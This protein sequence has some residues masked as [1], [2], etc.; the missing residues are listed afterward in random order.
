MRVIFTLRNSEHKPRSTRPDGTTRDVAFGVFEAMW[1]DRKR[2]A[3]THGAIVVRR[4]IFAPAR[5]R[6]T[7]I[8]ASALLLLL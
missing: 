7:V 4:G 6:L 3:D 2:S 8:N 5:R 1:P